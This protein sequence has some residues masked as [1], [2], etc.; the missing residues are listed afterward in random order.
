MTKEIS[1]H[2]RTADHQLLDLV[3]QIADD[4]A[5]ESPEVRGQLATLAKAVGEV[6]AHCA[7][8]TSLLHTIVDHTTFA[9]RK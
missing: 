1:F 2:V 3:K 8:L 6:A 9:A 4:P 5:G 7:D